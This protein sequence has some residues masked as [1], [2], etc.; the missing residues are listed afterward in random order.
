MVSAENVE[1]IPKT[2]RTPNQKFARNKVS[3]F[4]CVDARNNSGLRKDFSLRGMQHKTSK[5]AKLFT[6]R[7]KILCNDLLACDI[8]L[9][10]SIALHAPLTEHH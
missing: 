8:T 6:S 7:W 2:G 3:I 4:V 10:L 1:N 9:S 5:R